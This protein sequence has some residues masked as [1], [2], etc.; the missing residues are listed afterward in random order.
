MYE[1]NRI[2]INSEEQ[3]KIKD[4]PILFAGLGVG[5]VI[6]ECALRLGFE[7]LT[8]VDGDIVEGNNLNRQNYRKA[9]I[10]CTK[11]ESLYK[12]L[13]S[14]N[15]T[16]K[17]QFSTTYLDRSNI[18]KWVEGHQVVINALDFDTEAPLF[19]DE[20]CRQNQ[21]PV[22]HPYNLGWAGAV[23][24]VDHQSLPLQS[25]IDK[26]ESFTEVTM[27]EYIKGHLRY[28]GSPE[29]WLE[30]VLTAYINE[31]PQ[32]SPPQLSIGSWI[33]ASM[34]THILFNLATDLKVKKFPD[35]YFSKFGNFQD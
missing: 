34:C 1:R 12:R 27:V 28:W 20:Y 15:P 26:T 9:D 19:L 33:L 13:I 6:A 14:I 32:L 24:V 7:N 2:Y 17:I 31:K 3:G 30:E 16:S 5:S 10:S 29:I 25:I 18:P 21:I 8:L 11:A 4:F 22:L 23:A 35:F